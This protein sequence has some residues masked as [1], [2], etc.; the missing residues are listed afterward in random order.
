MPRAVPAWAG[1]V[2]VAML[3]L[4][5]CA[6]PAG[7]DGRREASVPAG[8]AFASRPSRPV[9]RTTWTFRSGEDESVAVAAAPGRSLGGDPPPRCADSLT[10]SLGAG[11][12]ASTPSV[13]L[14]FAGVAGSWRI[15][16]RPLGARQFGVAF[17]MDDAALSRVLMLLSGGRLEVGSAATPVAAFAL[18][19]SGDQ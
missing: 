4:A 3:A 14:R 5:G 10:V 2:T 13:P 19:P 16:A 1:A 11:H 8:P 7:E 6:A 17:A 18:L 9:I 15:T 12:D